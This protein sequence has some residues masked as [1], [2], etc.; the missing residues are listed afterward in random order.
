MRAYHFGEHSPDEHSPERKAPDEP[1]EDVAARRGA[2]EPARVPKQLRR[3]STMLHAGGKPREDAPLEEDEDFSRLPIDR[4]YEKADESYYFRVQTMI[5]YNGWSWSTCQNAT[6]TVLALLLQIF[7]LSSIWQMNWI[8]SD[9]A[10]W[11]DQ[12]GDGGDDVFPDGVDYPAD[13]RR[14]FRGIDAKVDGLPVVIFLPLI[15][16][17]L[18]LVLMTRGESDECRAGYVLLR[19]SAHELYADWWDLSW[20]D[21][22]ARGV[23]VLVC[24][25]THLLR[26]SLLW[27]YYEVSANMMGNSS[28]SF[29]LLLDALAMTFILEID[30]HLFFDLPS[31]NFYGVE[32]PSLRERYLHRFRASR[33]ALRSI[34]EH[35]QR[36]PRWIAHV[37]YLGG[38][39]FTC[40][41]SLIVLRIAVLGQNY[42]SAGK[43]MVFDDDSPFGAHHPQLTYQYNWLI[44]SML[45][46]IL[47]DEQIIAY[48]GSPD[49]RKNS[50]WGV[51][52]CAAAFLFECLCLVVIRY[53]V[54]EWIFGVAIPYSVSAESAPIRFWDRV[55]PAPNRPRSVYDYGSYDEGDTGDH[56][57]SLG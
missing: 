6:I 21:A 54:I 30:N 52:R 45:F 19:N 37:Y 7:A 48:V 20:G 39:L 18:T 27:Y 47:V 11:A 15:L 1:D 46:V 28:G 41:C 43:V 53:V 49:K 13:Y 31:M 55:D 40:L 14:Y 8:A 56:H 57:G 23:R 5:L 51:A 34:V 3:P 24:F 32:D 4:L 22:G 10:Q 36:V 29:E 50:R 38:L 9:V 26:V 33:D 35:V 12:W 42:T 2:A 44:Y 17:T 16:V 25:V